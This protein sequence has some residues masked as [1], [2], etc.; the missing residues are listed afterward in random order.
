[1]SVA[2]AGTGASGSTGVGIAW[3]IVAT[4]I[5]ISMD[6]LSKALT[7][8]YPLPQIAWARFA[9]HSLFA[10][11]L[12]APRLP[13]LLRSRRPGVQILRSTLLTVVTLLMFISLSQLPLM[14][15]TAITTLTPVLV[16]ALSVPILKEKVGWRR[17]LG[18][19]LGLTGALIVV[20]PAMTTFSLIVLIPLFSAF[21]NA[22]Y[23]ITTRLLRESDPP[24][25][26]LL[27]TGIVGTLVG[28][29]ALPFFWQAPDA[30]GWGL[31]ALLGA[32]GAASHYCLILA[33]RAAPASVV[34]P[35]TYGT[36]VWAP[37]LGFIVFAELPSA[38]TIV[39]SLLIV[40]SGL[41]IFY[42][43]QVR[44]SVTATPV[45]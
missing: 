22:N 15:V 40:G 10:G 43:E 19:L 45:P 27:Y 41:Y 1:M 7:A 28:S 5:F 16:T 25:T 34:A 11:L 12:L 13:A 20:G 2:T 3:M 8:D 35:F 33:Y 9:F 38:S 6:T 23:M 30:R 31:L 18:V 44:S 4:L 21:V 24:T 26:T 39:G 14:L 29:L 32:L 17:W 36:I 37:F 42:R